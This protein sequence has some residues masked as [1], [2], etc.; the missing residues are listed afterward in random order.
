MQSSYGVISVPKSTVAPLK[1]S[2]NQL[3]THRCKLG[4]EVDLLNRE[5]F[6]AIGLYRPKVVEHGDQRAA[7][8]IH[9]AKLS[10]SSLSFAGG[11]TGSRGFG[12]K[13]AIDDGLRAIEQARILGARSLIIVSGARGLHTVKHCR[14]MVVDGVRKLADSAASHRIHLSLLPMHRTFEREWTFL[15]SL[16]AALEIIGEINKPSVKLAFDAWQLRDEPRLVERIPEIASM[17]GIVQLSDCRLAAN[18]DSER[19]MP[20]NGDLPI[21][22]LIRAFQLAGYAGYFDIQ[23]WSGRVWQSNYAQLL[24]QSYAELRAMSIRAG[25]SLL[26]CS[27]DSR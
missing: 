26:E 12:Y 7:E 21:K 1:L 15:N 18:T 10:V 4:D 6:D 5:G 11:F 27:E 20:G 3:T 19:L 25:D 9:K 22:D 2:V 16:D 14:K 23:V 8:I 24:E 13:E 17:T